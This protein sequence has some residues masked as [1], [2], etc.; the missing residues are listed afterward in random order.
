MNIGFLQGTTLGQRRSRLWKRNEMTTEVDGGS[1]SD[2]QLRSEPTTTIR[3]ETD[4]DVHDD[5]DDDDHNDDMIL[6][7]SME[8]ECNKMPIC[9]LAGEIWPVVRERV[10]NVF[11]WVSVTFTQITNKSICIYNLS[12]LSLFLSV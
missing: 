7:V 6:V 10:K 3:H 12:R 11:R 5:D 4:D 2:D 8:T 9:C 1:W